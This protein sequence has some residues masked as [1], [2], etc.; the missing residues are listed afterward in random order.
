MAPAPSLTES[1]LRPSHRLVRGVGR[2]PVVKVEPVIEGGAYAAKAVVNESFPIRARVFREGHDQV[3]ASVVLTDP[4]GVDSRW[5]MAQI[6][7]EGLDIWETWVSCDHLGDWTFRVEGWSDPWATWRQTAAIKLAAGL[8][9]DLVYRQGHRLLLRSRDLAEAAGQRNVADKLAGWAQ[10]LTIAADPA[11]VLQI[12]D[13]PELVETMKTWR[14]REFVSPTADFPLVVDRRLALTSSW[15]EFFPRSQG[16]LRLADGRWVSG[17]L[18][19]SHERLEAVAAMGFDVVYLPPIHPIGQQFRKGPDNSLEAGP[20]DP[21]SPWAIGSEAG[22]HDAIHPDLGD[23][24]A[25]DRFVAKARALGLEVALDFAL[26]TSPDHPWVD[27]HPAWF[28]TRPDGSIAYAENPPKKYQDIYPLNF[29]NDPEGLYRECERLLEFWIAR[30]VTIF[31]VDNPHT[32]PLQFWA[33]LTRQIRRRHPEV[34]FLAEAFTRPEMMQA[35]G[36]VGFHQSYT[37]FTWRNTKWELEEFLTELSGQWAPFYRPNFFVNT[38]DIN[39]AFLHSG[40]PAAFAI[41]AILAATLS[42]SWGVYSGFELL[43]HE[44]LK[45]DGEEYLHSEKYEYRPRD[46]N[47]PGNLNLLLTTLNLVRKAHPALQQLRRIDFHRSDDDQVVVFSKRDGSDRVIVVC[48][49]DPTSVRQAEI[50]LDFDRLGLAGQDQIS[51]HDQLTGAH[52]T[53]RPHNWVLLTPDQP[54]HILSVRTD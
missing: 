41:R 28:T 37:Y 51:V 45:A 16:A 14:V 34:L 25:F 33:W 26:Q 7:P 47:A 29:D 36:Q 8:D 39:P 40:Q 19:S 52:W 44:P 23:F 21:G 46:F 48:S 31:R 9:V 43:E 53:W 1:A 38:P 24:A 2:I 11:V 12:L 42:P 35:L 54:A 20:N 15:Y 50:D 3:N 32:K 30:G 49:L 18:D 10:L 17:N 27:Q 22:G 6:W 13:E 4:Q 5:E